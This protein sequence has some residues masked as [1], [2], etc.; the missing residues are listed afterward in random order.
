MY[1]QQGARCQKRS[2]RLC[3]AARGHSYKLYI[4]IYI[5]TQQNYTI[6]KAATYT[7]IVIFTLAAGEAAH[8]TVACLCPK[9]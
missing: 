8:K 7:T 5:Y 9:C 2:A 6:I 4:Y 1:V 3:Y